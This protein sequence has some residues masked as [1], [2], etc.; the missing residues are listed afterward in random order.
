MHFISDSNTESYPSNRWHHTTC[1]HKLLKQSDCL[2]MDTTD[3][4]WDC[5]DDLKISENIRLDTLEHVNHRFSDTRG[6]KKLIPPN[7]FEKL[8]KLERNSI[9]KTKPSQVDDTNILNRP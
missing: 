3:P 1:L 9:E 8:H 4:K 5:K 7:K 6:G 2:K